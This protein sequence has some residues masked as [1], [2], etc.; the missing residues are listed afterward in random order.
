M[1]VD[2]QS[3]NQSIISGYYKRLFRQ[4]VFVALMAAL[5]TF[6][7]LFT[8]EG[9]VPF[10]IGLAAV[11]ILFLYH[12]IFVAD[13]SPFAGL[14]DSIRVDFFNRH[15]VNFHPLP[16]G[17]HKQRF[18]D[19]WL[20]P[21][22]AVYEFRDRMD[23]TSD[24]H[25]FSCAHAI[26]ERQVSQN[27]R[28]QNFKGF[29]LKILLEKPIR[30][31]VVIVA[32]NRFLKL[33]KTEDG[34]FEK[35]DIGDKRLKKNFDI[36]ATD[37]SAAFDLLQA[38][39]VERL[40]SAQEMPDI[41]RIEAIFAHGSALITAETDRDLFKIEEMLARKKTDKIWPRLCSDLDFLIELRKKLHR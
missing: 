30:G 16:N 28:T 34:S 41:T 26:V 24:Q 25:P 31:Q 13:A 35:I 1:Q 9:F 22:F 3:Q 18:V 12:T 33:P 2:W 20:L 32:R 6:A 5:A 10:S 36:Y 15:G 27:L 11:L 17:F 7:Y 4:A 23:F 38:D 14:S 8:G 40:L 19:Y 39:F 21:H 29:L 37:F